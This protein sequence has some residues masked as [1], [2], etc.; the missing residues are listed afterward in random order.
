MHCPPRDACPLAMNDAH[1]Q[2]A[3]LAAFLQI[4]WHE[5][6]YVRQIKGVQIQGAH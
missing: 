1:L 3:M 5:R 4:I 2:D 6:P